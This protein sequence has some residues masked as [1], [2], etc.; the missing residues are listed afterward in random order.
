MRTRYVQINGELV[1][2]SSDFQNA[3]PVA[4]AVFGDLPDYTSPVDGTVV[5]GRRGRRHDLAR[6][7]CRPYEG[8]EAEARE[9]NRQRAYDEQRQDSRLDAAARTAY[10][11]LSPEKRRAIERG[12]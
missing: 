10:A 4:P 3:K 11:Q 5:H 7:N 1:L 8:R 12:F 6:S 2:V 9:A